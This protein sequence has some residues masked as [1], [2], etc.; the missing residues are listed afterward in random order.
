MEK[1]KKLIRKI[2]KKVFSRE[3]IT[4]GVCGVLTTL[5]N[6]LAFKLLFENLAIAYGIANI[7]AVLSAKLFAY[8]ANKLVVFRSHCANMKEL[9]IEI[10]KYVFAR[11]F[12]GLVDIGGMFFA[13]EVLQA[14]EMITKYVIQV[15]VIVLNYVLGKSVVFNKKQQDEPAP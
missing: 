4:Y 14:D 11:G 13:V 6:I 1:V 2:L 7:I 5:V 15:I 9:L 12:T 10:M 3:F 8:L